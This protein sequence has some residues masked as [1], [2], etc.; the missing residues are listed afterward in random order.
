MKRIICPYCGEVEVYMLYERVH[1]GLIFDA[2]NNPCG[3]TEDITEYAS[4]VERCVVCDRKVKIVEQTES[5]DK[6]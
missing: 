5:E 1:R 3:S 6:P 4:K 2:N